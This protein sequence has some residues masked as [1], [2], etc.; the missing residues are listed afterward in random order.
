LTPEDPALAVPRADHVVYVVPER[1]DGGWR[2]WRRG[3]PGDLEEVV[4]DDQ[5]L[6]EL[7]SSE[8]ARDVRVVDTPAWAD[9]FASEGGA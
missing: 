2:G 1:V 8:A 6:G 7:A 4:V 9:V 3:P 5:A